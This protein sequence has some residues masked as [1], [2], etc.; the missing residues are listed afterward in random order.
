MIILRTLYAILK[1][2]SA[3]AYGL[4]NVI[5]LGLH[6]GTNFGYKYYEERQG[7]D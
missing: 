6:I 2:K 1:N 3:Q 7:H 5:K 4:I